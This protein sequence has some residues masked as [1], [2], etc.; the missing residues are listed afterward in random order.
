M[1]KDSRRNFLKKTAFAT[2]GLSL[3]TA[4]SASSYKR[5]LG[6]NDRV[7]I[8]FIGCG[9]F[10]S[11]FLAQLNNLNNIKVNINSISS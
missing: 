4:S 3:A 6:A 9:K 2:A 5:I 8:A 7:N 1:N 10:V 11:M